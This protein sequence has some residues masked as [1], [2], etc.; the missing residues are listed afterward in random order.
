MLLR[1]AH[2]IGGIALH[3]FYADIIILDRERIPRE[4]PLLV[5]MNHQN[6]LVDAL[7]AMW[8]VPR[9]VRITAKATIGAN[10]L[11]AL[12]VRAFGIVSLRRS[13]DEGATVDRN[14]NEQ[15]FAS[16][17]DAL[18]RGEAVLMFPEGRSHSEPGIAPL[19]TGLARAAFRARTSGVRGIRI[20]PIGAAFDDKAQPATDA[21]LVV[22]ELIDVDAWNGDDPHALTTE[23]ATRLASAAE[24]GAELLALDRTASTPAR[25]GNALS[26]VA[27]AWG[28]VTH[29][30]PLRIARRWALAQSDEPDQPAMYTMIFGLA[31]VLLFYL[32]VGGALWV[33]AG[34]IAAIV[35]IALLIVGADAAAHAT[36][37]PNR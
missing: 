5:A 2:W 4:G 34:P 24:R 26:R 25:R 1:F 18:R 8:V 3:W 31:L 11:G 9:D 33:I 17:E 36:A 6:A 29:R 21:V 37:S 32:L 19:K 7:L 30:I 35:V 22:G 13:A 15:A 28:D 14:R 12:L 23:L 27:A 20:V 10:P 16:I